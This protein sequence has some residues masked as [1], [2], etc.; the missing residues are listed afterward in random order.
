M[1]RF[2]SNLPRVAFKTR[3]A[4]TLDLQDEAARKAAKATAR[5][6]A[7]EARQELS[8]GFKG[9]AD[10]PL[11]HA[12]NIRADWIEE[13][14]EARVGLP[15]SGAPDDNSRY[16]FWEHGHMNVVTGQYEISGNRGWLTDAMEENESV[17]GEEGARAASE[18]LDDFP[19]IRSGSGFATGFGAFNF[20]SL[21]GII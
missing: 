14:T 15:E 3:L 19:G 17:A 10:E 4:D 9:T 21:V 20:A 16:V 6:I 5:R 18:V 1:P 11:E 7:E 2:A 13:S 8:D 12:Q